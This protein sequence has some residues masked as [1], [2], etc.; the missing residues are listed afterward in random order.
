VLRDETLP[1]TPFQQNCSL[2]WCDRTR[3]AAVVDPGGALE[4][5]APAA[6]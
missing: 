5:T 4:R 6:Q 3:E 1:V 2:I